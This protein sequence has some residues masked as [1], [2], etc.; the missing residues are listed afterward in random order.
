MDFFGDYFWIR[1]P[2]LEHFSA[3]LSESLSRAQP[4]DYFPQIRSCSELCFVA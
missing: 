1:A 3:G 4:G 2:L